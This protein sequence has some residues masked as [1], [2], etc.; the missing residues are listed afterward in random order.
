MYKY[1]N[2]YKYIYIKFNLQKNTQVTLPEILILELQVQST[3]TVFL[4][5][6]RLLEFICLRSSNQQL[7]L[8]E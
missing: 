5:L 6:F 1:L 4:F 3:R 7:Y 2:T 8:V